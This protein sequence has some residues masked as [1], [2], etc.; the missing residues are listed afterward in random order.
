VFQ[1]F[2]QLHLLSNLQQ[3]IT[4][5]TVAMMPSVPTTVPAATAN[6]QSDASDVKDDEME[7][8]ERLKQLQTV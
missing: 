6:N 2:C 8:A 4:H 3:E 5:P 1:A 7:L